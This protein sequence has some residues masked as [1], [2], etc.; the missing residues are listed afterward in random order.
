[1]NDILKDGGIFDTEF[2][3][4]SLEE[5]NKLLK[6]KLR[7]IENMLDLADVH[8]VLKDRDGY[9]LW[10]NNAVSS[11]C[12]IRKK[13][14]IGIT[15]VELYFNLLPIMAREIMRNDERAMKNQSIIICKEYYDFGMFSFV[16]K[17]AK[18]PLKNDKGQVVGVFGISIDV[19]DEERLVLRSQ[20]PRELNNYT[21]QQ[22][23][24]AI[25][26]HIYWKNLQG[27]Y[28]VCN[29]AVS[30]F[31]GF[32]DPEGM[33]GKTDYD[34]LPKYMADQAYAHDLSVIK[35]ELPLLVDEFC[36]KNE[37]NDEQIF[38]SLKAPIYD[39]NRNINGI[40][41]VSIDI[42]ERKLLEEK[43]RQ[44]NARLQKQDQLKN[45]FVRNFSHDLSMPISSF[46]NDV[47]LLQIILKNNTSV[48][49]V[50]ERF[51]HNIDRLSQMF[52]GMQR[53][54]LSGAFDVN[55]NEQ[56][57]CIGVMLRNELDLLGSFISVEKAEKLALRLILDELIPE[58]IRGDSIK[59]GMILRNLLSNAIK[60]TK[61]GYVELSVTLIK[62]IE[63][64]DKTTVWLCFV[65]SD[66][67]IGI[68]EEHLFDIFELG[69]R[70][71]PNY[72]DEGD[73]IAG[74]GLGLNIVKSY[75]ALLSGHL[76]VESTLG[77]G[78]SCTI[79]LPFSCVNNE[80]A[81]LI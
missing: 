39:E 50:L 75:V 65:V 64:E 63:N 8:I 14:I 24:D 45:E 37:N 41:G 35:Q 30:V 73:M 23:I 15:D 66:T 70:V 52:S 17:S 47:L 76:A 22:I 20:A 42:T 21:F 16:F 54:F 5:E 81:P 55:I 74:S 61:E 77:K 6:E 32:A 33:F 31:N 9:Y 7:F 2:K 11:F 57:F 28:V 13:E 49:K 69:F 25:D 29:K 60:Y 56:N 44:Q 62:K 4:G 26:G 34:L 46:K 48:Q 58:E 43:T 78:T 67:G 27:R 1:M 10:C 19:T 18:S 51:S 3:V 38:M 12:G 79:Q 80:T 53:E 71:N 36:A 59:L 40:V 68:P 72:C